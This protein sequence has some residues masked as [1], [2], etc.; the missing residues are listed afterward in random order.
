M[1]W[2]WPEGPALRQ[3]SRISADLGRH[4][5]GDF[6]EREAVYPRENE[7]AEKAADFVERRTKH[8]LHLTR[9]QEDAFAAYVGS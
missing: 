9:G 5:G 8:G 7:W 6:R 1:R 2:P 3:S 4:F